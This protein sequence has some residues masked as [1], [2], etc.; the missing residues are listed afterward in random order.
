M[1]QPKIL[2]L[3]SLAVVC[4]SLAFSQTA[5]TIVGDIFDPSGT[6][7]PGAKI[8]VTNAGTKAARNVE[9][10]S[11]GQYRVT[12][13]NPGQYSIQVQA[14]GFK[15]QIRRDI[16]LQVSAVLEV[17]FSLAL[18][19]VAE[20]IEVTGAAPILQTEEVQ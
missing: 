2:R 4:A 14:D 9:S 13:L 15:S 18:G 16:E 3:T 8:T 5:A 1:F 10:N 12:P 20:T 6:V 17:D 7:I 19:S 11:T